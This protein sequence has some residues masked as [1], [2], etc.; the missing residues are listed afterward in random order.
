[1]CVCVHVFTSWIVIVLILCCC[2]KH[3]IAIILD[4]YLTFSS[5]ISRS[6]PPPHCQLIILLFHWKFRSNHRRTSHFLLIDLITYLHLYSHTKHF[7]LLQWL[8]HLFCSLKPTNLPLCLNPNPPTRSRAK[9]HH[10]HNYPLTCI[11]DSALSIS[12]FPWETKIVLFLL[13]FFFFNVTFGP[14]FPSANTKLPLS[15]LQQKFLKKLFLLPVS[16]FSVLSWSLLSKA[17][18]T[19]HH[20]NL[21][22]FLSRS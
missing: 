4:N 10:T 14:T 8:K 19:V 13:I 7:V 22:I 1:M 16:N 12:W 2:Q 15:L 17:V 9:G 11:I 3:S 20:T 18:F 6:P 5:Q 21:V